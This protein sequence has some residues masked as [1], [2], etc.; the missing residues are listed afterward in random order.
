MKISN[1]LIL[2]LTAFICAALLY[3]KVVL[4][5]AYEKIDKSS[6][7]GQY[8]YTNEYDHFSHVVVNGNNQ[9]LVSFYQK[10]TSLMKYKDNMKG[11][12]ISRI[13]N[14]T[15]YLDF[16]KSLT[17]NLI[18]LNR[19]KR[20]VVFYDTLKS[21]KFTNS[22]IYI[23]ANELKTLKANGKGVSDFCLHGNKV[24]SLIYHTSDKNTS[25]FN[26]GEPSH[27][28]NLIIKASGDSRTFLKNIISKK[29][30]ITKSG[31]AFVNYNK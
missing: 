18:K 9:G 6:R 20:I 2:I 22:N 30:V 27:I 12:F 28:D 29:D 4:K 10:G 8:D 11:K 21:I 7:F 26:Y 1:L 19:Y 16:D 3:E 23:H 15:L 31:N 13:T 17:A 5:S 25:H 24:D 14:D